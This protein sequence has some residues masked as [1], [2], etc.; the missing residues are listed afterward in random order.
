MLTSGEFWRDVGVVAL[1]G[2]LAGLVGALIPQLLVAAGLNLQAGIA[3]VIFGGAL[4][5][6]VVSGTVT[7]LLTGQAW[8]T[9]LVGAVL[10]GA[11]IGG[12]RW[13]CGIHGPD[14]GC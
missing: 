3:V 1:S 5:G 2:A 14:G 8:H 6:A 4:T 10:T 12:D 11:V 9:G 13:R 7:N